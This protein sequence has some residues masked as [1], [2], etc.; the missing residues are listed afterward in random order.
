VFQSVGG[1]RVYYLWD[2]YPK[3]WVA[4]ETA[5]EIRSHDCYVNVESVG[6]SRRATAWEVWVRERHS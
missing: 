3:K 2:T 6:R 5:K 1:L 4:E